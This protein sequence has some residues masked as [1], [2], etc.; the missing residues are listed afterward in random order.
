MWRT[1][2]LV[3]AAGTVI[4]AATLC[5]ILAQSGHPV[6][7]ASIEPTG[8][9]DLV[10]IQALDPFS[11]GI[12]FLRQDEIVLAMKCFNDARQ[13]NGDGKAFAYFGYCNSRSAYHQQ[14]ADSYAAAIGKGFGP[15]WVHSAR[16][17]SLAQLTWDPAR[18]RE[19][20][21]EAS[22]ARDLVQDDRSIEFNWALIRF[23][24]RQDPTSMQLDDPE[25]VQVIKKVVAAGPCDADLWYK[26]ALILAAS[27]SDNESMRVDAI[28]YLRRAVAMG[29]PAAPLRR[30]PVFSR[31]LASHP[32]FQELLEKPPAAVP[33]KPLQLELVRPPL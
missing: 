19:S 6:H 3:I 1:R 21:E 26:A 4:A 8:G 33:V 5:V 14:A 23:L 11:R 29:R 10:K 28:T 25:C 13:Q 20:M 7:Q 18:M 17:Y 2:A 12:E 22:T 27:S 30:S 24:T 15:A 32:G 16:A 9:D 31:F